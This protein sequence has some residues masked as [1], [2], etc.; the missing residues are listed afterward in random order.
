MV[1]TY[2]LDPDTGYTRPFYIASIVDRDRRIG[3]TENQTPATIQSNRKL[4]SAV[5]FERV[6]KA[7]HQFA[8]MSGSSQV[9]QTRKELPGARL[10]QFTHGPP[11]RL[12]QFR[13]I[14]RC[15]FDVHT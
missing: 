11:F 10:A 3:R 6:G 5:A 4:A 9:G 7:G 13:Q 14:C 12:A 2:E 15:K 8:N 1:V